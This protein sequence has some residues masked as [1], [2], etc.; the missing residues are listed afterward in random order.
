MPNFP[1]KFSILFYFINIKFYFVKLIKLIVINLICLLSH[2][3]SYWKINVGVLGRKF[4]FR[5]K[6]S[7]SIIIIYINQ[8]M[9]TT[10]T[11]IIIIIFFIS[12]TQANGKLIYSYKWGPGRPAVWWKNFVREIKFPKGFFPF[13]FIF[14]FLLLFFLV[15]DKNEIIL[16][17]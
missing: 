7:Q 5:K 11:T 8:Q 4:S 17:R 3:F 1:K 13:H 6:V 16:V 2:K 14:L 12:K 10:T 9:N 15:Y